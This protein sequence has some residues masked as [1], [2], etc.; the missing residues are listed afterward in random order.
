MNKLE[1]K[2]CKKIGSYYKF[3]ATLVTLCP[4][5]ERFFKNICIVGGESPHRGISY[6]YI[7][8]MT[9]FSIHLKNFKFRGGGI[10]GLRGRNRNLISW[11]NES[12]CSFVHDFRKFH[13]WIQRVLLKKLWIWLKN[14]EQM[15]SGEMQYLNSFFYN[16][17]HFFWSRS[18][19]LSDVLPKWFS[20]KKKLCQNSPWFRF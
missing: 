16:V 9:L 20:W 19:T 6:W 7:W 10:R 13:V 11:K 2:K 1:K 18:L 3:E 12:N 8:K 14:R 15:N 4:V 17:T 5:L